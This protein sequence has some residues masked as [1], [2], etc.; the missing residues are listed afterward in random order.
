MY[1][2]KNANRSFIKKAIRY[3]EEKISQ[4]SRKL[5]CKNYKW[6]SSTWQIMKF[7][8][9][10][11]LQYSKIVNFIKFLIINIHFKFVNFFLK[12]IFSIAKKVYIKFYC[13]LFSGK[14]CIFYTF[15]RKKSVQSTFL[16]TVCRFLRCRLAKNVYIKNLYLFY[17][18]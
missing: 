3:T 16:R 6:N 4:K 13:T 17:E 11:L 8:K 18:I 1:E 7:H 9:Y 2:L 10:D 15:F 14:K 12:N 5:S